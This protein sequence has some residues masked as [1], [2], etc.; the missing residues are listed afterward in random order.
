MKVTAM[1]FAI[2]VLDAALLL[3]WKSRGSNELTST[4]AVAVECEENVQY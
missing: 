3:L 2:I 1:K 4:V